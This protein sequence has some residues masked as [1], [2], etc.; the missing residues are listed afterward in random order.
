MGIEEL[1]QVKMISRTTSEAPSRLVSD[2]WMQSWV[3]F[4]AEALI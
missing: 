2:A 4:S 1:G 3:W